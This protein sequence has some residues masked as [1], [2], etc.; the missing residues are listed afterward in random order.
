MFIYPFNPFEF[1]KIT[2]FIDFFTIKLSNYIVREKYGK[3]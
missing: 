1:I 2:E 3:F